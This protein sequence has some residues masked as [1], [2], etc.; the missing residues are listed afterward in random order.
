MSTRFCLLSRESP[1]GETGPE[2]SLGICSQWRLCGAAAAC[3]VGA[4]DRNRCESITRKAW[5]GPGWGTGERRASPRSPHFEIRRADGTD[6]RNGCR[7]DA[8]ETGGRRA[9]RGRDRLHPLA[10]QIDPHQPTALSAARLRTGRAHRQQDRIPPSVRTVENAIEPPHP[11]A[12]PV[13]QQRAGRHAFHRRSRHRP[14][15]R[16]RVIPAGM[17]Q[18]AAART[19]PSGNP[20][21]LHRA[22][23]FPQR[24]GPTRPRRTA[25]PFP[26]QRP[27]RMAAVRPRRS[28]FRM[29]SQE[30]HPTSEIPS[31]RTFRTAAE[32]KS[33]FS[34]RSL[35]MINP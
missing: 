35:V 24:H 7:A 13:T 25:D 14:R 32:R 19:P 30:Y 12:A 31:R 4:D 27:V 16:S 3:S 22:P 6:R 1:S 10:Q 34:S 8:A 28:R 21:A 20:P 2:S 15:H 18:P 17:R 11:I 29:K 5:K 33:H 9:A 23:P 26:L